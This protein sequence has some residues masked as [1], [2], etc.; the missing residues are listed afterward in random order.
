[1]SNASGFDF[2]VGGCYLGQIMPDC[3]FFPYPIHKW[4]K[5]TF[6]SQYQKMLMCEQ[7]FY[8]LRLFQPSVRKNGI[9]E[10]AIN[11]TK[12]IFLSVIFWRDKD[13][14]VGGWGK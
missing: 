9:Y 2:C 10:K 6:V 3:M 5:N 7:T 8:G 11:V 14:C 1:M 4:L 13:D 12:N